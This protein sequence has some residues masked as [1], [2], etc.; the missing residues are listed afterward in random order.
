[1]A[2]ATAIDVGK[3]RSQ[4]DG[5]FEL[6]GRA[7]V[8]SVE[9]DRDFHWQV[10]LERSFEMT[11]K[12]TDEDVVVGSLV[13]ELDFLDHDEALVTDFRLVG[14]ILGYLAVKLGHLV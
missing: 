1:M 11:A 14:P 2:R 10:Q 13:D 9:L 12:P 6:L 3:L 5:I 4:V 7:G 8:T